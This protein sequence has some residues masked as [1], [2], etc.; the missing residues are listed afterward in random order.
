M[1]ICGRTRLSFV[2]ASLSPATGGLDS[3]RTAANPNV[4][5]PSGFMR[6]HYHSLLA[7]ILRSCYAPMNDLL[8]AATSRHDRHSPTNRPPP[9][10]MRSGECREAAAPLPGA[11]GCPP[12]F[13]H[14][15]RAGSDTSRG[16]D[17]AAA[18]SASRDAR[19]VDVFAAPS[20]STLHQKRG[21]R[22]GECR[23]AAALLP[24]GTGGVPPILKPNGRAG[25]QRHQP[26]AKCGSVI[27]PTLAGVTG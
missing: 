24:G 9:R 22:S 10:M 6:Q 23:G 21:S 18:A 7:P 25:G 17:A 14:W 5:R 8:R 20:E 13:L 27:V 2:N 4:V 11:R 12:L 26:R 15:G 1:R 16:R 19:G 3:D